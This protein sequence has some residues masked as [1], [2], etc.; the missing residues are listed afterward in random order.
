MKTAEFFK[1]IK[2]V[3][4]ILLIVACIKTI[5]QCAVSA[6]SSE[7]QD[8]GD[9]LF[10][11]LGYGYLKTEK[12]Q[13]ETSQKNKSPSDYVEPLN[14]IYVEGGEFMMGKFKYEREYI[15]NKDVS[16]H[17]VFVSSFKMSSTEITQS[18]YKEIMQDKKWYDS[19]MANCPACAIPWYSAVEFCNRLSERDGFEKCYTFDGEN[20]TCNFKANGYRLPTEAEWEFAASGGNLSHGYYWSGSDNIEEISNDDADD[21]YEVAQYKPNE[22]GLYDMSGNAY[23]WCWDWYGNGVDSKTPSR[24]PKGPDNNK[25]G[26]LTLK[27]IKGG[28]FYEL[29]SIQCRE[30]ANPITYGGQPVGFRICQSVGE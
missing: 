22:L 7:K 3:I 13:I 30:T 1:R 12:K 26:E 5:Y 24:N 28:C 17:K 19:D 23:E 18:L 11:A 29:P 16:P 6:H 4:I 21:V 10:K 2:K 20:V 27:V 14:M 9:D 25:N 15:Y 8:V